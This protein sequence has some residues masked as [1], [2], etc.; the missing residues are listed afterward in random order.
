MR[1]KMAAQAFDNQAFTRPVGFGHQV[2]LA[3]PLE[4]DMTLQTIG[5]ERSGFASNA[6][7]CFNER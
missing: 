7:G 6:S 5:D 4:A 2:E 1:R 3:F